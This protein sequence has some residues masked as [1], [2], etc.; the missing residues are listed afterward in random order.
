MSARLWSPH[1][2]GR[3]DAAFDQRVLSVSPSRMDAL[4][5]LEARMPM[6]TSTPI[7][8]EFEGSDSTAA[9]PNDETTSGQSQP[10][11]DRFASELSAMI[12]VAATTAD[13]LNRRLHEVSEGE[14]RAAAASTQL[15]EQLRLGARML[16]AFQS[17]ITRVE[18]TLAGH[19]AYEQQ[20]AETQGKIEQCFAGIE[21]C[22]DKTVES[23]A[24]RLA[25]QARI[26]I[27][28]FDEGIAARQAKLT[29]I[30]ARMAECAEGINGICEMVEHVQASVDTAVASN[31]Q[32]LE[33]L[34]AAAG[35]ARKLLTQ[36]EQAR[37]SLASDLHAVRE[38][39]KDVERAGNAAVERMREVIGSTGRAEAALRQRLVEAEAVAREA[40][41]MSETVVELKDLLTRL[42]PWEKLLLSGTIND[43]GL[44]EP[45]ARVAGEVKQQIS[46]D[47]N[48]LSLTMRDVAER[49]SNLASVAPGVPASTPATGPE[50]SEQPAPPEIAVN[51][52]K[53][54]RL[55]TFNTGA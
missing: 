55:R 46:Q 17:Q 21:S 53:P 18:N 35:D 26:A 37:K 32:T 41:R 47:M 12:E 23:V 49:V 54:L 19:Q 33:Q 1:E 24:Y 28:R 6:H 43:E 42:Q 50:T 27:A 29:E 3:A 39:V 7:D 38:E 40:G 51:V 10:S 11:L 15:Q 5:R 31:Q 9:N 45:L 14:H 36:H 2:D 8:A 30:D 22:V 52:K 44:P 20:V 34:A 16:K 4:A 25:E 13:A 48:W